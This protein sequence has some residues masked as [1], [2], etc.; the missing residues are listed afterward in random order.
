MP[1][2]EYLYFVFQNDNIFLSIDANFGLCRKKAAGTSVCPPL[3]RA[4]NLL[5]GQEDIDRFVA[6]YGSMKVDA[7]QVCYQ[8]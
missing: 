7:D 5:F 3:H 8:L 6:N 2:T 1:H 4:N